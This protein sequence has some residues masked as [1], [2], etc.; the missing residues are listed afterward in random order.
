MTPWNRPSSPSLYMASCRLAIGGRLHHPPGPRTLPGKDTGGK[1][2]RRFTPQKPGQA[3]WHFGEHVLAQQIDEPV[4]VRR[5]ERLY[6]TLQH[7]P[8][9]RVS[10]VEQF[11]SLSAPIGPAERGPAGGHCLRRPC[12]YR[13]ARPLQ[14]PATPVLRA[15]EAPPAA[16]AAGVVKQPQTPALR[17]RV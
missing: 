12:W 3:G 14:P 15:T 8:Q 11:V 4:H 6:V 16:W 1:P 7:L 5:F 2:S 9:V 13:A 17:C 10:R